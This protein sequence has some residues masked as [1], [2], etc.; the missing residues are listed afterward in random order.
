MAAEIRNLSP[1]HVWGYF[2]DLTQIPRPTGHMDAVTRYI[3]AFGKESGLETLQDKTGNIVIRKPATPGMEHCKTVIIQGHLDMVPQKNAATVHNFETDPIDAYIDGDWVTARDTTLG[4]DNGI[5]VALAL[6]VLSDNTLKHGPVE[7]LFTVDEEVGM[8]GAFGLKPGFLKGEILINADS[9]EEGELFVGCAGGADLNISFQFKED[10]A[11]PEGDVAVKLSLTGLKGGHSGVDIHL[12]RANANKLMFRFLKEAVR[13]YGARLS[14]ID[15]GSLRNAIPREAV[16]IIT[17]PGDNVEALWELVADYQDM[18]RTEYQGI[19]ESVLF[20]AEPAELPASLIPEE[21]QDDLINA[22]EGCQNGVISML[23]DFP[24][25][26]ETSTNL[27]SVKKSDQLIEIKIL[28]RSSS[29]SRKEQICSSL[30]SVFAL[31]GAKVEYGS[32]YG[33]WQP[34]IKSEILGVMQRVYEQKFGRTPNVKVM[35]AG[36]ECGI[37]QTVYPDMDMIS[38]GPDLQYPHSPDERVSISSVQKV[39]TFLTETLAAM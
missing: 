39:W 5:G 3:L 27:A 37:I 33:G 10:I 15:G 18:F 9:E 2:H 24:G 28:T 25:T 4:A 38:F 17:I 7:A 34:N 19:E 12:G 21:I 26:V 30:E 16:A 6:A 20:V 1:Q 14:S 31:A 29:E 23:A 22:I 8:D 35:H 32:S 11:I 36:L 13:D